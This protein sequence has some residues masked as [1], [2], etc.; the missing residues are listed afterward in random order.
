M[1]IPRCAAVL[2]GSIPDLVQVRQT[3]SGPGLAEELGMTPIQ[4][5]LQPAPVV[6]APK[7]EL[8]ASLK[9]ILVLKALGCLLVSGISFFMLLAFSDDRPIG[10]TPEAA[11]AIAGLAMFA[12][13]ASVV[14]LLGVA[15]TWSF[16][17]WGVYVL[18]GFSMLGFVVRMH[19][20]DTFGATLGLLTTMLASLPIALR[21]QDFE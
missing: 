13:G 14:E 18:A 7:R 21:W 2:I 5:Q 9:A 19:L 10:M 1:S 3:T 17:R 16:K 6:V 4:F 15:G 20:G 8:P 11:H 12:T